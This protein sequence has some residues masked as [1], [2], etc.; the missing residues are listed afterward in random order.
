MAGLVFNEYDKLVCPPPILAARA[1][2]AKTAAVQQLRPQK[3][4]IK[5]VAVAAVSAAANIP[6]GAVREHFEKFSLGWFVAVH[7][8]IP[9]VAMLRK[10]VIM[11]KYV[12]LVTIAAAV[13]GQ[14]VGSRL[15]RIRM[16]QQQPVDL[17]APAAAASLQL[18]PASVAGCDMVST[19]NE[20]MQHGRRR[21]QQRSAG[22]RQ[23][24]L[25]GGTRELADTAAGVDQAAASAGNCSKEVSVTPALAVI[26][27]G[28]SILQLPVLRA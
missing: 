12:I 8:T 25:A 17:A 22:W 2:L 15:E 24:L 5:L 9:F 28:K 1:A 23:K 18:L 6:C 21:P 27:L 14:V 10:A 16:Q 4:P 20:H 11:P 19:G 3:L 26:G 13:M 7:A